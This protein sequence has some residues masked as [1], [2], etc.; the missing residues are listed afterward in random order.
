[1]AYQKKKFRLPEGTLRDMIDEATVDAYGNEE[2][3]MGLFEEVTQNLEVPFE[4]KVLGMDVM[5]TS[6]ETNDA[7][8]FVAICKKG[9]YKQA[10][11]LMDLPLPKAR[12]EGWEWIEA[13]RLWASLLV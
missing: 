6:I 11:S 5:V 1:M 3:R 7:Y 13:Y 10:I 9:R 2:Q 8:D 4:T 12:P